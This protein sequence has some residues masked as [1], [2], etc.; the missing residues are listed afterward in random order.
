MSLGRF[1]APLAVVLAIAAAVTTTS[2][3]HAQSTATVTVGDIFFCDPSFENGVCDTTVNAGDTVVWAFGGAELAH[4][5]TECGASCD[6]PTASPLW[7]SGIVDD[8]SSFQFTFNDAG[9]YLYYCQ[10][11][12]TQMLGRITV[13]AAAPEQP[14]QP[15]QPGGGA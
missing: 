14:T 2:P 8:G 13:Q 7:D 10:V 5:T 12:L 3:A 1:V 4:T 6:S 11:H 15:Q 9:T